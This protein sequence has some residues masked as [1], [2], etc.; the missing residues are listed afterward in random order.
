MH[1]VGCLCHMATS[2]V[3]KSKTD[4]R[5]SLCKWLLEQYG[6]ISMTKNMYEFGF[7]SFQLFSNCQL[8]IVHVHTDSLSIWTCII[9]IYHRV[10]ERY[11]SGL[12]NNIM[13]QE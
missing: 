10:I 9:I 3:R 2:M 5:A 11:Q 6:L 4:F 7:T 8:L 12:I 13:S 1:F